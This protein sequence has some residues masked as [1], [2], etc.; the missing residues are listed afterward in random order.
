M[1][2][3]FVMLRCRAFSAAPYGAA[4]NDTVNPTIV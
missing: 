2:E 1:A 4:V 3:A